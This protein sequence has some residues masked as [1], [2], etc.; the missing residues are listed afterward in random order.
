MEAVV[1]HDVDWELVA[2]LTLQDLLLQT[3]L[4]NAFAPMSNG[5][6]ALAEFRVGITEL[7]VN[8][9]RS[10]DV[11]GGEQLQEYQV[12]AIAVAQR[13]FDQAEARRRQISEQAGF[14]QESRSGGTN[15]GIA[16]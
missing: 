11:L 13:F 10:P 4:A 8:R 6:L 1:N 14:S 2:K 7:L 15:G 12:N 16:T 5:D 3:M 9:S